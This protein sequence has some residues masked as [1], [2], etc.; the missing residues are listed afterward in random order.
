M[1]GPDTVDGRSKPCH[2]CSCGAG[3][4]GSRRL[5][6]PDEKTGAGPTGAAETLRAS[7]RGSVLRISRRSWP[8]SSSHGPRS[9]GSCSSI[10][11][12]RC[13]AKA[14]LSPAVEM[15]ICR[16]PRLTTEPKKKSQLGISSTLLHRMPRSTQPPVNGSVYLRRV[17]G[18]DDQ[19][20][21]VEVGGMEAALH[22]FELALQ[23]LT[24]GLR[25]ARQ[26]RRRE[27]EV[28]S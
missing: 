18:G 13:W 25:A 17:C 3:Q 7:L 28:R 6:T 9:S 2:P 22:P 4:A 19:A 1:M 12:R 23:R 26:A 10:S 20:V 16:S 27:A 15:A 24:A 8:R 5:R 11:R 21:A 14:G